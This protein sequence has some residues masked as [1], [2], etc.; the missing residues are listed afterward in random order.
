[1]KRKN[2]LLAT[3]GTEPQIV[4]ISLYHF[5]TILKKK[6]DEVAVITTH[7]NNEAMKDSIRQLKEF[8]NSNNTLKNKRLKII[9]IKNNNDYISD[10]TT[11]DDI[12]ALVKTLYDVLKE[13][14]RK[15]YKVDFLIAGGRKPMSI[16][17]FLIASSLFD[18]DDKLW[19][20]VSSDELLKT[21]NFIPEDASSYSIV[22]VPI[23][24]ASDISPIIIANGFSFEQFL[25]EQKK[26]LTEKK[27]RYWKEFLRSLT[28]QEEKVINLMFSGLS[29]K[30]IAQKLNVS[31]RTVEHHVQNIYMKFKGSFLIDTKISRSQ[32]ISEIYKMKI[33]NFAD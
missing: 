12:T 24:S 22:E 2:I 7:S 31:V 26:R 9:Y 28:K 33:G 23:I 25:E 1:M 19:Y 8:F 13:Y 29:N 10:I 6:I 14:K 16:Y 21:K 17:S 32:F 5:E 3:L 4:T 20:L 15:E 11:K 27:K 30:E 18:S